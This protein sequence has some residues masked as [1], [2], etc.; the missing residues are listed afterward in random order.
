VSALRD[1]PI[2]GLTLMQPWAWAICYAGKRIENRRWAPGQWAFGKRLAIHAGK[3]YDREADVFIK[4][5]GFAP[6][7]P[8]EI[9]RGAVVATARL[10]MLVTVSADPWFFGPFGWQ[11]EDV[12]VLPEPIPC[13]GLQGLWRLP[14]GVEAAL[15]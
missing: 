7:G 15:L 8:D 12:A 2:L 6:P 5:L 11:L 1:A 3:K 4:R 13:T 14:P 10:A 9:V